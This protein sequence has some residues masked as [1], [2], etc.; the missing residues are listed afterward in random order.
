MRNIVAQLLP[1][2]LEAAALSRKIYFSRD[3]AKMRT[4]P[5]LGYSSAS[6]SS[7]SPL[8]R[9]HVG[10]SSLLLRS[11]KSE[12]LKEWGCERFKRMATKWVFWKH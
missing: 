2:L 11:E 6:Y 8:Q 4:A 5:C 10:S 3:E 9:I 7:S 12:I 1:L